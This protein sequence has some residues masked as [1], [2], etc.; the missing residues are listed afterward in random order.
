MNAQEQ[1]P[2]AVAPGGAVAVTPNP[3]TS[4]DVL[5]P[6]APG[7]AIS[8]PVLAGLAKQASYDIRLNVGVVPQ[9]IPDARCD[10]HDFTCVDI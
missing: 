3:R 10:F 6:L 5:M 7:R 9:D 8:R 4:V 2:P 1:G